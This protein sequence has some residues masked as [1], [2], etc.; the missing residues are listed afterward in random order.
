V[1]FTGEEALD[2]GGVKKVSKHVI[3]FILIVN[4]L[5]GMV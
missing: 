3:A 5:F 2:A 4:I 1:I